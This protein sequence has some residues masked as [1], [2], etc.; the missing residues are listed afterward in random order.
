MTTS[1]SF[2]IEWS[3]TAR[4]SLERLPEKVA[5]SA[6]EYLYGPLA[7]SPYRVGKSLHFELEGLYSAHRGDYRVLYEIDRERRLI[8]VQVIQHRS[9]VYRRRQ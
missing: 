5:I 1:E 6:L 9:D 3:P 8:K 2:E 7:V 4:R